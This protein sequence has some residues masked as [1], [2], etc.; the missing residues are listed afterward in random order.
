[1]EEMASG[2]VS[3]F[4]VFYDGAILTAPA[5]SYIMS[6]AI[7]THIIVSSIDS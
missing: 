7:I 2:A 3:F 1:M 6:F 5:Y 4:S